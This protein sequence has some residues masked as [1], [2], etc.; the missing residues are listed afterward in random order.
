LRGKTGVPIIR[1][2]WFSERMTNVRLEG[3]EVS[4]FQ[5]VFCFIILESQRFHELQF[6]MAFL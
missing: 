3:D 5:A 4:W 2:G 1:Q 6:G